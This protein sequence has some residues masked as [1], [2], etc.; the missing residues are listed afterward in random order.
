MSLPL[1][2]EVKADTCAARVGMDGTLQT[3]VQRSVFLFYQVELTEGGRSCDSPG[4]AMLPWDVL[5]GDPVAVAVAVGALVDAAVDEFPPFLGRNGTVARAPEAAGLRDWAAELADRYLQWAGSTAYL[6]GAFERSA[7]SAG[8]DLSNAWVGMWRRRRTCGDASTHEPYTVVYFLTAPPGPFSIDHSIN[9]VARFTLINNSTVWAILDSEVFPVQMCIYSQPMAEAPVADAVDNGDHDGAGGNP[10]ER[11]DGGGSANDT[12]ADDAGAAT[13]GAD[14]TS[15]NG[16][17][18]NG[19]GTDDASTDGTSTDDAGTNDASANDT[20]VNDR[21]DKDAVNN[22][23]SDV[24]WFQPPTPG[25]DGVPIATVVGIVGTIFAATAATAILIHTCW[26]GRGRGGAVG[27]AA[28]ASAAEPHTVAARSG[29][30][31]VVATYPAAVSHQAADAAVGAVAPVAVPAAAAAAAE[32]PRWDELNAAAAAVA[33]AAAAA[34]AAAQAELPH[35]RRVDTG[36]G[37]RRPLSAGGSG[38]TGGNV[39]YPDRYVS[40]AGGGGGGGCGPLLADNGGAAGGG[41]GDAV[42][43]G[44]SDGGV[45]DAFGSDSGGNDAGGGVGGRG[46]SSAPYDGAAEP[47]P[48]RGGALHGGTPSP[49]GGPSGDHGRGGPPSDAPD[50]P[51]RD[52]VSSLSGASDDLNVDAMVAAIDAARSQQ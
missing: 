47:L 21:I 41:G 12:S 38:S 32:A 39:L 1:R 23:T 3:F 29:S 37:T 52:A 11:A 35:W 14:G 34:A 2:L 45:G 15:T 48:P 5:Q 13:T 9:P 51:P 22:D 46:F 20:S 17:N 30:S 36:D 31:A 26:G 28:T 10:E 19:T 7:R 50:P 18:T 16:M 40:T 6:L 25:D 33:A 24:V 42:G 4:L 43:F 27:K 44:I 8:W 49:Q